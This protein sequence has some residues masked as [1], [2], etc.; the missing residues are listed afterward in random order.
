MI[1]KEDLLELMK[2]RHSRRSYGQSKLA[3]QEE[4]NMLI[5]TAWLS[6]S[7]YGDEPWRQVICNRQSN[8]DAWEKLLS[9]PTEPNKK[10][11]KDTQMLIISLSTKNFHDH[12]IKSKFLGQPRYWCS[13]LYIYATGY[14]YEFNAHQMSRFDRNKIVKNSI[15]QMILI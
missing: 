10:W 13:K 1:S 5:E 14:I 6:P 8:Q 15:Y 7:R 2:I 9:C 11:A 4:I 12:T 3:H